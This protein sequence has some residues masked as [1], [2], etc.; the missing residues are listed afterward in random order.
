[1]CHIEG[2]MNAELYQTILQDEL[3]ATLDW[4]KL[5]KASIIFQ[6]D[7][8]PKHTAHSTKIWLEDNNINTLGWPAQSPDLR[9]IENLGNKVDRR[10][11]NHM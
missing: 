4:Y 7:N 6:H 1:M 3:I 5:D 8:D 11:R 9:L 2:G 10:L